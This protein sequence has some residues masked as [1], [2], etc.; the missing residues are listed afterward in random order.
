MAAEQMLKATGIIGSDNLTVQFQNGLSPGCVPTL[1]ATAATTAGGIA[2]SDR[3]P[4]SAY[5]HPDEVRIIPA[6]LAVY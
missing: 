1:R 2:I 5:L 6:G 3:A 4:Q